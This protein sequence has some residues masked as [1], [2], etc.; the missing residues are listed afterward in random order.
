MTTQNAKLKNA[1]TSAC[2]FAF[3]ILIFYLL[4]L[5]YFAFLFL[6]FEGIC[7]DFDEDA[8]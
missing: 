3:S 7:P 5:C 4:L 2:I 8:R 1:Y 6:H